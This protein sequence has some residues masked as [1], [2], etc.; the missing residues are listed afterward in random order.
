M[1]VR[2][3]LIIAI[4]FKGFFLNC[5]KKATMGWEEKNPLCFFTYIHEESPNG[6]DDGVQR[7]FEP[8]PIDYLFFGLPE[9]VLGKG[10]GS[11]FDL[12]S[13]VSPNP[14]HPSFLTPV[15]LEILPIVYIE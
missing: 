7:I 6:I 8:V 2:G 3:S 1:H 10:K 9:G 15:E 4:F 14:I 13:M 11:L 5:N 12:R